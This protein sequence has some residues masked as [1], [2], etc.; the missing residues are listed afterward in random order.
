MLISSG[1]INDKTTVPEILTNGVNN[2]EKPKIRKGALSIKVLCTH[3]FR[4]YYVAEIIFEY[5]ILGTA[6]FFWP[7]RER[8]DRLQRSK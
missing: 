5:G 6:C 1:A 7:R 2:G 3:R 4:R 8:T